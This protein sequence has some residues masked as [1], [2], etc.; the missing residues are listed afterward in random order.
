MIHRKQNKEYVLELEKPTQKAKYTEAERVFAEAWRYGDG[1]TKGNAVQA[2]LKAYPNQGFKGALSHSSAKLNSPGVLAA[3]KDLD[4][5]YDRELL[6]KVETNKDI[7]QVEDVLVKLSQMV[8]NEAHELTGRTP[9]SDSICLRAAQIMLE[10]YG[11]KFKD[12]AV[13]DSQNN[14]ASVSININQPA[15]TQQ[16]IETNWKDPNDLTN[17]S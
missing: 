16:I 14:I 11:G 4:A 1:K 13:K 9:Y 17:D 2:Y 6:I 12:K 5:L 10:Y 15:D 3:L 8:R 7:V